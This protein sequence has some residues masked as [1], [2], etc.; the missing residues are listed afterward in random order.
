M[1]KEKLYITSDL[2]FWHANICKYCDRPYTPDTLAK[3]NE[4]ILAEFD[5]LP[6]GA[7]VLNLGDVYLNSR[8]T[9]DEI[10]YLVD[11]MK[12]N[13]KRIELLLGNHDFSTPRFMK[14]KQNVTAEELFLQLGFDKVYDYPFIMDGM[15]F[16]H[17]PIYFPEKIRVVHGHVHNKDVDEDYFNHGCD[18]WAM[19]EI[20]KAHPELT[21]QT[22]LDIETGIVRTDLKI[23]PSMYFNTCWD[24]HHRILS[25]D[26][27]LHAFEKI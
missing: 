5:K 13:G 16:C 7:T 21:K 20:V 24:K 11:R 27:V 2:H 14:G 6:E 19:M 26:E 23:N 25:Y 12:S 22:N 3:M 17:E 9:F 18:N 8:K 4:D 15:V 10:K 1:N